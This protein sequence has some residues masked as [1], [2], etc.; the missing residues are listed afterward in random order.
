MMH[1]GSGT[2]KRSHGWSNASASRLLD[3]GRL[4]AMQRKA[5]TT[6]K[7]A[8]TNEPVKPLNGTGFEF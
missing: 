1:S 3:L 6:H 2:P 5:E 8:T 4:S 7:L